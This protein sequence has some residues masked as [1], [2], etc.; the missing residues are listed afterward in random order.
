MNLGWCRLAP[1]L[2]LGACSLLH[3]ELPND[4]PTLHL[5][6]MTCQ[7]PNQ[8]SP[9]TLINGAGAVC[10]V[11]RGGE[12]RFE[13]RAADEDDD[14]V[15]Y[16]WK[17]P[18]G[19]RFR[20]SQ[21]QETNAWFAPQTIDGSSEQFVVQVLITDRNC[22]VVPD[23]A[24]RQRC[25]EDARVLVENFLVE[26]VQRAPVLE[27]RADATGAFAA[28][29]LFIDAFGTDPDDDP[30]EYHW[31]PVDGDRLGVWPA[32]LRDEET[33][34]PIGSRAAVVAFFPGRH[35]LR[36]AASDGAASA[37]R[38]ITLQVT[39][40]P[41]PAGGMVRLSL[42]TTGQAYEMD[43]YEYPNAQGERPQSASFF[44]AARQ[45]ATAGKRLCQPSEWSAACQAGQM[46][47]FS[48]TDDWAAYDDRDH[49]GVRFC[50][51]PG[52][53]FSQLSSD[54]TDQLAPSGSFPNCGGA[55]GIFDLTGNMD[56]WVAAIDDAGDLAVYVTAS[57]VFASGACDSATLVGTLSL[58]GRDPYDLEAL[59]EI[60]ADS[61]LQNYE[62]PL[63]G[64]R[65]CR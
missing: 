54:P 48:S 4:P 47:R 3:D 52:S 6:R 27:V 30:L 58:E 14:P 19:G 41:L 22:K 28:P 33:G 43:A 37:E 15:F 11:Q 45:C 57:S 13:I 64:F 65:C 46:R 12:I 18:A 1:L 42:P 35:K 29:Q 61:P 56:E 24:D 5:A 16:E 26:V 60:V 39:E 53:A 17:A 8:A 20:D 62:Q 44:H 32:A 40:P 25:D 10:R 36:V 31:E 59:A 34:Q 38:E 55:T 2:A 23:L 21:A 51:V 9:D 63:L 49:F 7:P 50:N